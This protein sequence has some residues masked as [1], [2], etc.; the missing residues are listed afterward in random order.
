[1]KVNVITII[2]GALGMIPKGLGRRVEEL[3][4]GRQAEI[5]QTT[6]LLRLAKTLRRVLET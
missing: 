4:N 1:M 3:E 6:V 5:I 2:I